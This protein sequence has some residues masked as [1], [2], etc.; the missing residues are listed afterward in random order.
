MKM[1]QLECEFEADVLTAVLQS[2][3]PERVPAEL[4]AHVAECGIC[5]DVAVIAG[6]IDGAREEM[7][8]AAVVPEAGRVWWKAQLRA[9]REAAAA[10]GRPITATQVLAF[11][12]A[13]GLIGACF[14]ATSPW[15]QAGVR[16]LMEFDFRALA[17]MV[18]QHGALAGGMAAVIFVIPAA[19]YFALGRD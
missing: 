6:A 11:A 16:S 3:W 2:R 10:A 17:A 13:V 19:V 15:F 8:A 12:C 4:R 5:A 7:G 1:K 14:G 18:A 9:R